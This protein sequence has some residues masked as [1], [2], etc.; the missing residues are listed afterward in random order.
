MATCIEPDCDCINSYD[1]D[2]YPV[3][4]K[5]D[6]TEEWRYI[7][8]DRANPVATTCHTCCRKRIIQDT[9]F[10][11]TVQGWV[12]NERVE[13]CRACLEAR[14]FFYSVWLSLSCFLHLYV[15]VYYFRSY[16]LHFGYLYSM[17]STRLNFVN[18]KD[19]LVKIS[20][21]HI[22]NFILKPLEA[23]D[24]RFRYDR[25]ELGIIKASTL[26][27]KRDY[28][29]LPGYIKLTTLQKISS[30]SSSIYWALFWWKFR[31]LNKWYILILLLPFEL[32]Q[33]I[34]HKLV[35]LI[36]CSHRGHQWFGKYEEPSLKCNTCKKQ[37]PLFGL[38][39][40]LKNTL[41]A[42]RSDHPIPLFKRLISIYF[43]KDTKRELDALNEFYLRRFITSTPTPINGQ[44]NSDLFHQSSLEDFAG[45]LRQCSS[46]II[47]EEW[48]MRLENYAI[49]SNRNDIAG[50]ISQRRI[51]SLVSS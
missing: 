20:S 25:R 21:S 11:K 44:C 42:L 38:K 7:A 17:T 9:Q 41:Y 26:K 30:T 49:K 27:L 51:N 35:S 36:I 4:T 31:M 15:F 14:S 32:L 5:E 22:E 46:E 6:E 29:H 39:I 1:H 37:L 10:V 40:Y 45:V 18:L 34:F 8:S 12:Y 50:L 28:G 3:W 16:K 2:D 19:L 48:L 43:Y 13:V 24:W 47:T 23:N 33:Y